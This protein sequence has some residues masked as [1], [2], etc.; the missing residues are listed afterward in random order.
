MAT[1]TRATAASNRPD[2]LSNL[3][4]AVPPTATSSVSEVFSWPQGGDPVVNSNAAPHSLETSVAGGFRAPQSELAFEPTPQP[5]QSGD[6]DA[7]IDILARRYGAG[8]QSSPMPGADTT[9]RITPEATEPMA[10]RFPTSAMAWSNQRRQWADGAE[11]AS[12]ETVAAAQP[13]PY[14]YGIRYPEAG[15]AH[16]SAPYGTLPTAMP[17]TP[18]VTPSQP[19]GDTHASQLPPILR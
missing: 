4:N 3:G 12:A 15:A 9:A 19:G 13:T 18:G 6:G 14:P 2:E 5:A 17:P 16:Y 7:R 1:D 10:R 8:Y 11:G